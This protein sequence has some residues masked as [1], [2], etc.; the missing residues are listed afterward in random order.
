MKNNKAKNKYVI[1]HCTILNECASRS[2]ILYL[3]LTT[4]S[5]VH[6]SELK[7]KRKEKKKK[8]EKGKKS[9]GNILMCILDLVFFGSY[10]FGDLQ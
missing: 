5:H 4:L 6:V 10:L 9:K 7:G 2:S 1:V 3:S 8:C